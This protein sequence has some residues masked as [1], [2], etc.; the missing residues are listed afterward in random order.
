VP[1][2][3]PFSV[4]P[5]H[6]AAALR[7]AVAAL[8]CSSRVS[9]RSVSLTLFTSGAIFQMFNSVV[10]RWALAPTWIL[11][12]IRG[13]PTSGGAVAWPLLPLPLRMIGQWLSTGAAVNAQHTTIYFSRN[14]YVLP[15]LGLLAWAVVSGQSSRCAA[16]RPPPRHRHRHRRRPAWRRS[17]E[18]TVLR[19]LA[20]GGRLVQPGGQA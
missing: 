2:P 10:G 12:V 13:S 4:L 11:L 5:T 7:W 17:G 14:Q 8:W 9:A 3:E 18:R 19:S 6:S 16:A 1:A 15:F 20:A